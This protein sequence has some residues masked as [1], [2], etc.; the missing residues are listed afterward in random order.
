MRKSILIF[1]VCL[2]FGDLYAQDHI[3]L[4]WTLEYE[5]Y[6]EQGIRQTA[7]ATVPG[8]VQ[9]DVARAEG[10]GPYYYAENW[11]DYLW[12]EDHEFTYVTH[13]LKPHMNEGERLVFYSLGIDYEF[14]ITFNGQKLMHQEGMFTPVRVDLTSLVGVNNELRIRIFP[15]PKKHL[16]PV[17]RSQAAASVKPAVSYGWDWH[18]R[19]IPSG[20]WDD[21]W[22]EVIPGSHVDDISVQYTLNNELDTAYLMVH[23]EGEELAGC[24]IAWIL[25]DSAGKKVDKG[26]FN[27]LNNK[28]VLFSEIAGP[29]LWWTHDHGEPYLYSYTIG[30]SD[31][32]GK[33]LQTFRGKLGFRRVRLVMNEGAW[34][35]PQGFP[36]SRSPVPIQM[37]LNGRRIFCKGSNW[38]NPEIFPG[39]ITPARYGE[40]I[41]RALEAN[42]NMFRVWGGG[43]VNKEPFYELCDE[44]GIL[45]WQE[46]P[47]ACNNYEATPEYMEVLKQEAES[48]IIRI[49]KHPS[50]A[51]WSG[52]NELFNSW[53]GMTDQSRAI[54]LLNSLCLELDPY[55]PFISTSPLMG[56]GHGHY[57]FRDQDTGEEVYSTMQKAH[58][59]AYTEFGVPSPSPVEILKTIIPESELWPPEPGASWESHHAFNAWVGDTWLMKDMIEQYFGTSSGLEELVNR[60]QLLQSEGYKAIFEE[61]R[62]Q[63]PYCSMALNWCYNEP[64]PTAANNSLINWPNRPK[65]AFYAVRDA[66]RPVMA[67]ARNLKFKWRRGEEF[68][69]QIWMLNDQFQTV[70]QGVVRATLISGKK[71]IDLGEWEFKK[72]GSNSNVEG[73]VLN[74]ILPNWESDGFTL[75]LDVIGHPEYNSNYTFLLSD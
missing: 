26:Y 42:F 73:P 22:L 39:T 64:W 63:K 30:L 70:N 74:T 6:G 67:S 44:A 68:S 17:D 50:L 24:S 1:V 28:G 46:F 57:V 19:L 13:F 72:V 38:V 11:K 60:G 5:K 27:T 56:M 34:N 62:R 52:G 49:R 8:A 55:T 41:N 48:I 25:S 23:A 31:Q 37:E 66:C 69:T 3:K 10:Y 7:A 20:I 53:S 29:E 2:F 45:V 21:T 43:I 9:L 15:V 71:V 32:N 35:E 54:R 18:P 51:L 40:L 16:Q 33:L 14:E 75:Y 65:P 4:E 47:L 36:K 61:A 12:M 58:F 59:T